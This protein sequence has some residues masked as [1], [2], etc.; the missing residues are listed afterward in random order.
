MRFAD[1]E[2]AAEEA[3]LPTHLYMRSQTQ[4]AQKIQA[5]LN[6]SY[7]KP[8]EAVRLFEEIIGKSAGEG[9]CIFPPFYT[10]FGLGITVGRNVF[11]N[12]G[13]NFQDHGGIDIGDGTLIG[14]RVVLA[15][16]NHRE[17]PGRRQELVPKPIV[18]G[19]NVWIGSGVIVTP[20]VTIGDGA[21]VAAGAVVTKDVAPNTIVA[22]VPARFIRNVRAQS[23]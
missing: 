13:C 12:S 4:R 2:A 20:G 7:H 6:G 21:I 15:T 17:E 22:G 5:E 10:D 1:I 16:L 9:F 23:E 18:I 11:I 19:K 8:E 3:G 14:H